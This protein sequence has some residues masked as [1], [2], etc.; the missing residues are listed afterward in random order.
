MIIINA[1]AQGLHRIGTANAPV[2]VMYDDEYEFGR[3]RQPTAMPVAAPIFEEP[4]AEVV[5]ID[6]RELEEVKPRQLAK[7]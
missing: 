6:L 7:L 3:F 2:Q 4:T 5:T 1:I